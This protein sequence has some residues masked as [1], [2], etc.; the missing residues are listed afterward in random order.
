VFVDP[1][2]GSD[3]NPGS[4]AA[5]KRTI[6]GALSVTRTSG[7]ASPTIILRGGTYYIN[8][9]ISLTPGD[10]GLTITAFDGETPVVSG[11]VPVAVSSWAPYNV[12]LN[13]TWGPVQAGMNAVYGQCGNP[14]V[15]NK[16][17]GRGWVWPAFDVEPSLCYV[18]QGVMASWEACQ[19]SCQAADAAACT[20]WTWNGPGISDPAFQNVCCWRTDGSYAPVPEDSTWSQG[21]SMPQNVWVATLPAGSLAAVPAMQVGRGGGLAAMPALQQE[22]N[23]PLSLALLVARMSPPFPLP[24]GERCARDPRAVPQL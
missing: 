8:A 18:A 3:V 14:G 13:A 23:V 9:T 11:G 21:R 19:A 12:T 16:A 4:Q 22:G 15:P 7:S 1:A 6:P 20:A 24:T 10:S 17:S 5:P 2:V